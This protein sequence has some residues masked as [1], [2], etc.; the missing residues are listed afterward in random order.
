M[1]TY[2]LS[3][4]REGVRQ[5][6]IIRLPPLHADAYKRKTKADSL[7]TTAKD[8]CDGAKK[9]A[10]VDSQTSVSPAGV[11]A[12]KPVVTQILSSSSK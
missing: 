11:I 2:F 10:C 4:V 1:Y 9:V 7:S 6:N 3:K 12:F 5:A 8:S